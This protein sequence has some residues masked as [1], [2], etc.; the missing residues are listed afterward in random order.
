MKPS[1]ILINTARGPVIKEDDL[2]AALASRRIAGAGLDV[3][4]FEPRMT[5]GLAN[6][7][8][9]V[10]TPQIGSATISSRTGMAGLA[11]RNLLARLQGERPECCL[12]PEIYEKNPG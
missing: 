2:V 5:E 3:Y 6:L 4:E 9:V 7:D 12:N 11:A 10:V 8:N 1:P